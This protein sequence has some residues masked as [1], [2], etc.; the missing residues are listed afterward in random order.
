MK[1][2]MYCTHY[3]TFINKIKSGRILQPKIE[4]ERVG[5]QKVEEV[6]EGARGPDAQQS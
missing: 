4:W 1:C 6:V 5:R 3:S 2:F